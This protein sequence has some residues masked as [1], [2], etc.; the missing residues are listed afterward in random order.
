MS[1]LLL[2]ALMWAFSF[3]LVADCLRRRQNPVWVVVILLLQ[4]YGGVGYLLYLKWAQYRG[5]R[6][7]A[8]ATA[9]VAQTPAGG[10]EPNEN[11]PPAL[12]LADRLEEQ[13]RFGEAAQLYRRAL[14][15][16]PK[17]PRALHG[18]ARCSIELEQP[19]EAIETYET[20]MAVDPRY[21][22]YTA[23]L[24]YAEALH[25]S[26]RDADATGLLEGLVEETGRLNH[27]LALAH[28]CEAAGQTARARSVL[29]EALV[30][31]AS[32]PL[33]EQEANRRWHRRITDKLDELAAG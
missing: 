7:G 3:W 22:N 19:H 32:S 1:S 31:Y 25:R 5:R 6:V 27:R 30:V 12:D 23:A 33:L 13:R 9:A 21:R 16:E 11:E 8:G 14:E 20:L 15:R 28:Y 29:S 26:G 17:D 24:E 10:V 18:L 4:P 2:S